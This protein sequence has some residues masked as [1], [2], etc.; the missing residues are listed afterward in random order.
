MLSFADFSGKTLPPSTSFKSAKLLDHEQKG[1]HSEKPSTI[2]QSRQWD[3]I[4]EQGT[5]KSANTV[6]TI[7]NGIRT[8]W[9]SVLSGKLPQC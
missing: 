5:E 8:E 7:L 3:A 2:F 1:N 9:E 4:E 6:K